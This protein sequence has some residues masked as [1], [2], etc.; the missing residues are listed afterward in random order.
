MEVYVP[1]IE[2]PKYTRESL[3]K[4]F[5]TSDIVFSAT[6]GQYLPGGGSSIV[7][8]NTIVFETS[9]V[10]NFCTTRPV[11]PLQDLASGDRELFWNYLTNPP[12][13][14]AAGGGG[15]G[16]GG[17]NIYKDAISQLIMYG[18]GATLPT[19]TLTIGSN[20]PAGMFLGIYKIPHRSNPTTD[21]NADK[22]IQEIH[23][24]LKADLHSMTN[25]EIVEAIH[26]AEQMAPKI[27]ILI[28]C[29][30]YDQTFPQKELQKKEIYQGA[31]RLN[32]AAL[33]ITHLLGGASAPGVSSMHNYNA[34]TNTNL[35]ENTMSVP[36]PE[37]LA[38]IL[39]VGDFPTRG[40]PPCRDG[41][42]IYI[43]TDKGVQSLPSKKDGSFCLTREEHDAILPLIKEK[44]YAIIKYSKGEIE[45]GTFYGNTSTGKLQGGACHRKRTL[46]HRKRR[47]NKSKRNRGN[48]RR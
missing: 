18:P 15:G 16:G 38:R 43:T 11:K 14:P 27:Y 48:A 25:G 40:K 32:A 26:F 21:T 3:K 10:G 9:A 47:L 24:Y 29:A 35:G 2:P 30:A 20:N 4:I 46:R 31:A 17:T 6:H 39:A 33:D 5:D 28:S 8:P 19:R 1:R 7:P 37:A 13:S 36:S 23:N 41:Y 22:L 44:L 34:E 45:R 42:G 12:A